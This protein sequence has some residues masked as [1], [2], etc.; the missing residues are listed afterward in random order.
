[1]VTNLEDTIKAEEE[2]AIEHPE[3]E[4]E[5]ELGG[6]DREEPLGRVHVRLDPILGEV[7]PQVREVD[8]DQSVQLV[9]AELQLLKVLLEHV[10]EA[11]PVGPGQREISMTFLKNE[12]NNF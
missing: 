3:D 11:V 5:R 10:P 6:E 7:L 9:E 1:M 12:L 4:E 8:L 2:E